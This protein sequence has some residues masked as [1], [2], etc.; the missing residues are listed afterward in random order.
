MGEM[1]AQRFLVVRRE[2][3]DQQ[4]AARTQQ[5]RGLGER[6]AGV[7]EEVQHLVDDDEI[8]GAALDRRRVDVALAQ[9][10]VA[11]AAAPRCGRGRD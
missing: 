8:V 4:T 3:D 2:I 7:V 1:L 10:D 11:Q 6:A 5:A 9:L